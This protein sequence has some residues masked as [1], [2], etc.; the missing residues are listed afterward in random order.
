M[1]VITYINIRKTEQQMTYLRTLDEAT[2][3]NAETALYLA[4]ALRDSIQN[5]SL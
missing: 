5:I 4:K 1:Y 3:A 2:K